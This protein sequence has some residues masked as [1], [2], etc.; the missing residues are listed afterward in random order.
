[1]IRGIL[2]AVAIAAA[3]VAIAI[4]LSQVV[5]KATIRRNARACALESYGT[6]RDIARCYAVRGLRAPDNFNAR[7]ED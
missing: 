3:G 6:D 2:T 7:N 1:M 5:A 4:A